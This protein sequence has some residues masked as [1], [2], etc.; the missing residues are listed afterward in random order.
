M[1]IGIIGAGQMARALGRG[2][3]AAGHEVF[4]G[5]RTFERAAELAEAIGNGAKAGGILQAAVFGEATL[6]A[7]PV[8]ALSAV[9]RESGAGAF[10]G[11]AL[12]D[13][14]NA[15]LPDNGTFVLTE[16]AVAERIAAEAPGAH[17]VKAFNLCAAELWDS[18]RR[19]FEGRPLAVP[20][21][22]DDAGALDLVATLVADLDLRPV[23]AGGLAQ[24]R[25]L[26]ATSAFVVGQWF[27]GNDGR[28]MIPPLEDAFAV[29]DGEQPSVNA[30]SPSLPAR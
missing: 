11:R 6:L 22:G 21:C 28:A 9:L 7:V 24:A 1:R 16:P 18:D 10:T 4:V 23:R 17:V 25:Y 29:P 2:W 8:T 5:A 26:E 19:S 15:F 27:S 14:T 12:I 20:L 30:H 3:A 13:C